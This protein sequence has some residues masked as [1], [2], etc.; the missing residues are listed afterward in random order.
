[1]ACGRLSVLGYL[2]QVRH[3]NHRVAN[4]AE[5][6]K[7]KRKLVNRH[8]S[9][10]IRE[11]AYELLSKISQLQSQGA[12]VDQKCHAVVI[13][14]LTS[15]NQRRMAHKLLNQL[16]ENNI[17]FD[18]TLYEASIELAVKEK[19]NQQIMSYLEEMETL[20]ISSNC[21]SLYR[22]ILCSVSL[23]DSYKVLSLMKRLRLR[24]S[25]SHYNAIVKNLRA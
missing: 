6:I 20:R 12:V 16:R 3:Y 7:I 5:F 2:R 23:Y 19:D 17:P 22:N 24:P 18:R 8:D 21:P 1:M 11:I 25:I 10:K 15:H 14:F 13:D 4:V 9:V